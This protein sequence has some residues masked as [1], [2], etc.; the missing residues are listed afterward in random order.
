M[1]THI[2]VMIDADGTERATATCHT[3]GAAW[4]FFQACILAPGEAVE[5]RRDGRT[6]SR[7]VPAAPVERTDLEDR[8]SYTM[9][10]AK[11]SPDDIA[12]AVREACGVEL[13]A[14]NLP[15]DV[16]D[17]LSVMQLRQLA[18]YVGAVEP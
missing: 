17:G 18:A 7:R 1:S 5:I 4:R 8:I 16:C 13:D 6:V 10:V 11:Y 14:D 2:L 3:Y 15:D 9:T 12:I